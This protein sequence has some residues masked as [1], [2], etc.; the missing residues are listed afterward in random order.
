MCVLAAVVAFIL[1]APAEAGQEGVR[2]TAVAANQVISEG[3][4]P[5]DTSAGDDQPVPGELQGTACFVTSPPESNWLR[6]LVEPPLPKDHTGPVT[7]GIR[8]FDNTGPIVMQFDSADT[9]RMAAGAWAWTPTIWRKGT[10]T[11]KTAYWTIE[12]PGFKHRELGS[13]FGITGQPNRGFDPLYIAEV[14][15]TDAGVLLS[16]D[17]P[18]LALDD[19]RNAQVT[20]RAFTPDGKPLPDG[21]KVEF[22][23]TLGDCHPTEAEAKAGEATTSFAPHSD[24]GEAIV[25]ASCE[26]SAGRIA[27][28]LLQGSG[29]VQ[30]IKWVAE[31]FEAEDAPDVSECYAAGAVD[32]Y[33]EVVPEAAH[34]GAFGAMVDYAHTG[35]L[36]WLNAGVAREVPIPGALLGI[37]FWA[38]LA[39]T[40]V[41]VRWGVH[42]VEGEHWVFLA[43][44]KEKGEDGWARY[45]CSTVDP[46]F[47]NGNVVFD[48]P[49]QFHSVF[50]ARA[51]WS[52]ASGGTIMIDDIVASLLVAGS[53]AESLQDG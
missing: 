8:Y 53:E 30:E 18:G 7:I 23:A 6:L 15:V 3:L 32:A 42:D 43:E 10:R 52:T 16:T 35:E 25:R 46:Y 26:F 50:L 37:S 2:R 13:D 36:P 27:L 19:G 45:A 1:T 17:V 22:S 11:W 24:E 5:I 41:E 4:K 20:A 31:D 48:Y 47:P 28:P 14:T 49:L 21:T 44:Q 33:L 29:G 38:K 12:K 51:P 39:E 9:T 34:T 40:H